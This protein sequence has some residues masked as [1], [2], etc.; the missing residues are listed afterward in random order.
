[1]DADDARPV[2]S[3]NLEGGLC[4]V[5]DIDSYDDS[6]DECRANSQSGGTGSPR[7]AREAARCVVAARPPSVTTRV[8]AAYFQLVTSPC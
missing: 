3:A 1:M 4:Q 6:D 7:R 5:V 2:C 8:V